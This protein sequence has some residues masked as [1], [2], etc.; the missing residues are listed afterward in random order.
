MDLGDIVIYG[1]QRF[2]VRGVDPV[3]V[4][5]RYLY[6]EDVRTGKTVSVAFE[7]HPAAKGRSRGRLRL[8]RKSADKPSTHGDPA[9]GARE[10]DPSP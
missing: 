10:P 4:H 1:G 5:P 3:G 9:E 2:Y 7:Q 6:L 8:V